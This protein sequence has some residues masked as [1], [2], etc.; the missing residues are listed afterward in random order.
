M[1]FASM[2]TY[3]EPLLQFS[4]VNDARTVLGR[5]YCTIPFSGNA[6]GRDLTVV[7]R[8]YYSLNIIAM[9][10]FFSSPIL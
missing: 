7:V 2:L 3:R 9:R 8:V 1:L 6:S 10:F 4:N 5:I